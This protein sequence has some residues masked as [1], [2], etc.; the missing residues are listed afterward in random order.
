MNEVHD[1]TCCAVAA[2]SD[3]V[4]DGDSV[5]L[6]GGTT[7]LEVARALAARSISLQ[8]VTNSLPIA[9]LVTSSKSIDLILIGDYVSAVMADTD[10]FFT[11]PPIAEIGRPA[12]SLSRAISDTIDSAIGFTAGPQ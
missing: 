5:L 3:L 4:E 7:T 8:V 11:P 9:Q 12:V 10:A 1:G 6:D 2:T